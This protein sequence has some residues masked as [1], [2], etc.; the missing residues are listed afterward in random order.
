MR[1]E[2]FDQLLDVLE[3]C[4]TACESCASDT[5]RQQN[6]TTYQRLIRLALDCGEIC[7]FTARFVARDSEFKDVVL[8]QCAI[9][10]KACEDECRQHDLVSAGHCA[11]V[12]HEAHLACALVSSSSQL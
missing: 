8:R 7:G 6:G 2:R 10:C 3:R 4:M 9:V 12:C 1:D 11:E 5:I